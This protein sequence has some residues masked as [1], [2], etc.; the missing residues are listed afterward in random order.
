MGPRDI[1][2]LWNER[3]DR[4][5]LPWRLLAWFLLLLVLGL[6][7]TIAVDA[8]L[9]RPI[10]SVFVLLTPGGP[11]VQASVAARN[12]AF[13]T[14]Q[15]VATIGSVYLAGRFLDRRRFREFGF[16]IDR[17]WWADLGFGLALGAVLMTGV[18]VVEYL[19]GWVTVTG[20][21]WIAQPEFAFW[22]WFA[23]SLLTYV[24]V[25]VYEELVARGY[26]VK[27]LSEGLTWF[28]RLGTVGAVAVATF[29][30]SVLF[31]AGHFTNPNA[32]L[33]STLGVLF[34]GLML[35]TGYVLT[36]QLGLPI[37]LH[38]TWNFFEGSVYGFPVSGTTH[39]LSLL[40]TEQRGPAVV[41][42]G[43]FGPEAGLIGVAA[44]TA[45]IALTVLWAYWRYGAVTIDPNIPR[46]GGDRS[47]PAAPRGGD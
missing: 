44:A 28:D 6:V 22:P 12:V 8:V 37:G 46:F 41:T 17:A 25:G 35:A 9:R 13:V 15:A 20:L 14:T 30:S 3:T 47:P 5:R 38:V 42:G 39:G 4:P 16:R 1:A 23:W 45:G 32:S 40:A 29:G 31:G 34:G 24:S 2:L 36:G 19:A 33:A 26:L 43:A 21:F 27:N 10:E 18:F 11:A 7:I